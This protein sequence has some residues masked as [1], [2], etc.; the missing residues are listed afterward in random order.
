M[1]RNKPTIPGQAAVG[2]WAPY[3]GDG[4]MDVNVGTDRTAS[5]ALSTGGGISP[6]SPE[7][8]A[9]KLTMAAETPADTEH[10]KDSLDA[11]IERLIGNVLEYM[12]T[13]ETSVG[14]ASIVRD[15]KTIDKDASQR[16]YDTS[17]PLLYYT[18][19]YASNYLAGNPYLER[20]LAFFDG[21][22]DKGYQISPSAEEASSETEQKEGTE[23]Q[24]D[25]QKEHA[26][27]VA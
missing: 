12:Q 17:S 3:V 24:T 20:V 27:R 6:A 8:V 11:E 14:M 15:L 4:D 5:V 13:G 26:L 18:D 1:D 16:D 10:E 9:F 2:A 23:E 22:R 7:D 25:E 19:Y 21:V